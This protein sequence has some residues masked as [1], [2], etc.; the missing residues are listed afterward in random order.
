MSIALLD[1]ITHVY[2]WPTLTNTPFTVAAF[3]QNT[4]G[5]PLTNFEIDFSIAGTSGSRTG[6]TNTDTNGI[7]R[8]SYTGAN[9]GRDTVQATVAVPVGGTTYLASI[10]KD[11]ALGISCDSITSG[12]GQS[13]GRCFNRFADE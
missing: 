10:A 1:I 2:G 3:L 11:W 9:L 13:D 12:G 7:A 4:N 8:F 6:S 5:A